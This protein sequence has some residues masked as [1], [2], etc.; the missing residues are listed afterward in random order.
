VKRGATIGPSDSRTSCSTAGKT[1]GRS[2]HESVH[3]RSGKEWDGVGKEPQG[4]RSVQRAL[5]ILARQTWEMPD[6]MKQLMRDLGNRRREAVNL[7][8]LRDV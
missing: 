6:E 1:S 3:Q 2:I 7:Y 5:D 4:V 8:V